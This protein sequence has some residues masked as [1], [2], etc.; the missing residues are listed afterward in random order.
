MTTAGWLH[1]VAADTDGDNH[2][3]LSATPDSQATCQ[4][5]RWVG[6]GDPLIRRPATGAVSPRAIARPETRWPGP[7][8]C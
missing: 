3:Q 5:A 1:L 8:P 6:V 7:G 2:I 4:V